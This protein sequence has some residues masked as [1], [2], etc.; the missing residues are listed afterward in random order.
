MKKEYV[1]PHTEILAIEMQQFLASSTFSVGGTYDGEAG[2]RK[3]ENLWYEDE[4]D[5]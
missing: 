5:E 4:A 1:S 2:V 3:D